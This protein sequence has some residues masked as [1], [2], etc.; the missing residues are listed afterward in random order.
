VKDDDKADDKNTDD[1][2]KSDDSKADDT[3]AAAEPAEDADAWKQQLSDKQRKNFDEE[4]SALRKH[5]A[6]EFHYAKSDGTKQLEEMQDEYARKDAHLVKE[7]QKLAAKA[8]KKQQAQDSKPFEVPP[9][10]FLAADGGDDTQGGAKG[11]ASQNGESAQQSDA[12]A[13]KADWRQ[14]LTAEQHQ[15]LQQRL[16]HLKKESGIQQSYAGEYGKLAQAYQQRDYEHK[17]AHIEAA[18]KQIASA[19]ASP[20][21]SAFLLAAQDDVPNDSSAQKDEDAKDDSTKHSD[22]TTEEKSDSK[23][24]VK[25][26]S[27]LQA[28][29]KDQLTAEQR[30]NLQT[31]LAHIKKENRIQMV[32]AKQYG[33]QAQAYQQHDYEHKV[34]HIEGD[35]KQVAAANASPSISD[36]LLAARH[37]SKDASAQNDGDAK[38]DS[39]KQPDEDTKHES[40]DKSDAKDKAEGQSAP[41]ADRK[42]QLTAEQNQEMQKR[43]ARLKKE[44]RI[45]MSFAKE[46]GKQAEASQQRDYER[47][48]AHVQA[49]F[50]KVA[51][52][53]ASEGLS[54]ATVLGSARLP[55]PLLVAFS[56]SLLA[57]VVFM[58]RTDAKAT[59]QE[60]LLAV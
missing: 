22:E 44:N 12:E 9:S 58:R 10:M 20:S 23:D 56:L 4:A 53:N 11:P 55:V 60:P 19:N 27:A 17:V 2:A 40:E 42:D 50:K 49:A 47:R 26:D 32:Y 34:A 13:P 57:T 1:K 5:A 18:F 30:G 43:L 38:A 6:H 45:Q 46:Y 52:A 54:L 35:F 16:A 7:Y 51:A 36:F 8:A 48:V 39:T 15:E 24:N 28:D 31:R 59:L 33:K 21:I 14:Q 37:D 41:Q 3:K 25:G 29:W